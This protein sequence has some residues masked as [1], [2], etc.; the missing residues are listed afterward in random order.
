MA[1]RMFVPLVGLGGIL[2]P[3]YVGELLF[4]GS[5]EW[6]GDGGVEED[7]VKESHPS[8]ATPTP[9]RIWSKDP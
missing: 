5:V 8:T 6:K 1:S 9:V 3:Y 2:C 4:A 7:V